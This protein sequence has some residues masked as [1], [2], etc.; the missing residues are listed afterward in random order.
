[1]KFLKI[2][3]LA[4]AGAATLFAASCCPSSAPEPSKPTY[5][6]PSK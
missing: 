1:M 5:Q 2:A 4:T 6:A 3:I